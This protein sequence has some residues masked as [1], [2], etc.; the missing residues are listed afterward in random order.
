MSE[1]LKLVMWTLVHEFA[2][3]RSINFFAFFDQERMWTSKPRFYIFLFLI[4]V[5]CTI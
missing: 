4:L 5:Q 1:F 2:Q 3:I